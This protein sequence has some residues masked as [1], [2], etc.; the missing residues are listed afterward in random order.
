[1][2]LGEPDVA[3]RHCQIRRQGDRYLITD[4]R[5]S[6]G[7]VHQRAAVRRTLAGRSRPDQYRADHAAISF[8]NG[9]AR[10][11]RIG[12]GQREQARSARRLFAGISGARTG[13]G[14][15]RGAE[16]RGAEPDS[17]FSFGFDPSEREPCGVRF[18]P[19]RVNDR[20]GEAKHESANRVPDGSGTN[21]QGRRVCGCAK[22]LGRRAALSPQR[23]GRRFTFEDSGSRAF[24]QRYTPGDLDCH[25]FPSLD[26]IRGVSGS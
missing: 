20:T 13:G 3:W 15:R 24:A 6:T 23:V 8:G 2:A 18:A 10:C 7:H 21:L 26:W 5:T 11:D 22:R 17:A 4:L 16:P 12:C 1:M 25:C 19:G 9:A 14:G